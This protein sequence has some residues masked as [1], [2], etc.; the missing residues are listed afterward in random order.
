MY[1]NFDALKG[2]ARNL[3]AT[4]LSLDDAASRAPDFDLSDPGTSVVSDQIAYL[5]INLGNLC[6]DIDA[7]GV[8]LG[9]AVD[10]TADNERATVARLNRIL[11]A[12]MACPGP[13][14]EPAPEAT[15]SPYI[16]EMNH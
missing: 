13:Q 1:I 16:D 7:L 10:E 14:P 12:I 15:P 5:L 2:V 6:E 9:R 8:G 4:A 11:G 3:S